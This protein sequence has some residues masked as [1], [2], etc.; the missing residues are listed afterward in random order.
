M[1]EASAECFQGITV[2]ESMSVWS[3]SPPPLMRHP[4]SKV[5]PQGLCTLSS[6]QHTLE[7]GW[8]LSGDGAHVVSPK[9]IL[10]RQRIPVTFC[11]L[12]LVLKC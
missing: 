2:N 9:F 3:L 8:G 6:S 12:V 5:R 4:A 7:H 11:F 10:K 1:L